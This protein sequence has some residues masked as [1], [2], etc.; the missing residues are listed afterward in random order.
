MSVDR[1]MK[2]DGSKTD[3]APARADPAS[4]EGAAPTSS[5]AEAEPQDAHAGDFEG[6][7]ARTRDRLMRALAE[8]E[9]IRR[10]A[11]RDRDEAVRYAN[12]DLA[13]DLLPI[14]DN[15]SRALD[16]LPEEDVA[17]E[18]T[19]QLLRGV[20]AIERQ[21][22]QTLERHGV[23]RF[24]PVGERFDPHYHQAVFQNSTTDRPEGTVTEVLQPGYRHHDRL[25][26]PAMVGVA[27]DAQPPQDKSGARHE[28][29]H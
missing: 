22:L 29:R 2:A 19:L 1:D 7:L 15:L 12:A 25:L 23:Q 4:P 13:R 20:A 21:M 14:V 17:D 16:S 5:S 3:G 10:R 8:Q 27:G 18:S 24:D 28:S 6:E 26:R 11:Q 9:N